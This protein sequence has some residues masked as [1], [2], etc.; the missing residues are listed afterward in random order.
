M[1]RKAEAGKHRRRP[2]SE[3]SCGTSASHDAMPTKHA[4]VFRQPVAL[5]HVPRKKTALLYRANDMQLG[6]H[7][8]SAEYHAEVTLAPPP[9]AVALGALLVHC[10]SSE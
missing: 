4:M 1:A 2:S 6:S 8:T 9:R 5:N 7:G 10:V 3:G